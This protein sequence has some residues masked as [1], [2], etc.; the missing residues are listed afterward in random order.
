M[1]CVYDLAIVAKPY[2]SVI[3]RA[4]CS[5]CQPLRIA[6]SLLIVTVNLESIFEA[7]GGAHDGLDLPALGILL[8]LNS[9]LCMSIISSLVETND[10]HL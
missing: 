4:K 9:A 10:E 2:C 5:H 7:L 3:S 1:S 6:L 8:R